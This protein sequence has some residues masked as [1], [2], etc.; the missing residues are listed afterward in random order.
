MSMKVRAARA[1]WCFQAGA[2]FFFLP[3]ILMLAQPAKP[4]HNKISISLN[5]LPGKTKTIH[6]TMRLCEGEGEK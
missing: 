3:C 5:S 6:I 4:Q 1:P 2:T